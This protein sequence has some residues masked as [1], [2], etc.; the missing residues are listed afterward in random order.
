MIPGDEIGA[1]LGGNLAGA[2]GVFLGKPDPLDRRMTGGDLAAEQ[3]DA[4]A[5][6]NRK[7]DTFGGRFHRDRPTLLLRPSQTLACTDVVKHVLAI[8]TARLRMEWSHGVAK[9]ALLAGIELDDLAA[10]RFDR[11]ARAV[12]FIERG[13]ALKDHR[14]GHRGP[15]FVLQVGRPGVELIAIEK[16]RA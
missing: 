10:L 11:Q 16:D 1:D 5:P 2:V 8:C 4:P 9:S 6:D 14:S 13:G 7:P 15:H 12:M 3:T